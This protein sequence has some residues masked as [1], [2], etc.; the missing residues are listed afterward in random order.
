[1]SFLQRLFGSKREQSSGPNVPR[2]VQSMVKQLEGMEPQQARFLAALAYVLVRAAYA[3]SSLLKA[4]ESKMKAIVAQVGELAPE[5]A[6]SLL[7]VAMQQAR[8]F[9]ASQDYLVTQMLTEQA[10]RSQREQVLDSLLLVAAA[11]D[12]IVG[13]E[14]HEIRQIAR[15]LGFNNK[16][17]IEALSKH[18]DKRSILQDLPGR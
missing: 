13:S 4:E 18:R 17:F 14:E 9:G 12:V 2:A 11:D 16:E 7:S 3:D 6:A 15:Q 10:T 8:E 1:M 5:Q